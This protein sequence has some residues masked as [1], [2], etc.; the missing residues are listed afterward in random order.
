[1]S[2]YRP[3]YAYPPP[4]KGIEAE[5]YH[6]SFDGTNTPVLALTLAGGTQA[7]DIM[8]PLEPDAPF[9]CRGIRIALGTA[10]SPLKVKLKTPAGDYIQTADVPS[11]KWAFG[12]GAPVVGN[13]V[14]PLEPEI[15]CA[16]GSVWTLY[17]FNPTAGNV[18][19][20]AIT[21]FGIKERDC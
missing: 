9:C 5:V 1:M 14:V 2:C 17:L 10:G 7:N 16:A 12:G 3:Q 13:L 19:P 20:P 15:W 4:A 18:N 11:S 6:Y 21:L 8:L